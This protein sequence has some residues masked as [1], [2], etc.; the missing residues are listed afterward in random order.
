M[1]FRI[2]CRPSV[3]ASPSRA[4]SAALFGTS[5]NSAMRSM[6]R[7]Y[8]SGPAKKSGSSPMLWA[9]AFAGAGVAGYYMMTPPGKVAPLSSP[10]SNPGVN[11]ET[12]QKNNLDYQAIYNDIADILEDNDYDDGSFGPVLLRLAWHASGTYNKADGSGGSNGATMRFRPESEHGGNAGLGVARKKLEAI[13]KK[14]PDISYSD[15][16]SL[17]GVV[18]VQEMGGPTIPW[19][20]GRTD[21][22]SAND[23]T[24][25]GRLPD[26][27]KDASHIRDIF[28]RM[29]FNDQEIV[30]LSGAHALGRC[31]HDRSGFEGPWT[32]SPTMLTNEYYRLLLEEQ[33]VPKKWNGP[34]QYVDKSTGELMMLPTDMELVKDSRFKKY[35]VIYAKDNDKFFEDFAKA[36]VK[37]EELGCRFPEDTKTYRFKSTLE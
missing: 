10:K 8:S 21:K 20:P 29:G 27:A 24:P 1:A 23:C 30:A 28:Y 2:V 14:Y 32:T 3:L 7:G 17:A 12:K 11:V 6:I 34:F 15:L 5:R 36:F 25:D 18:A 26:G 35:T 33:W 16:W 31:H 4:A 37:L 22:L 9:L 19:R 13:K